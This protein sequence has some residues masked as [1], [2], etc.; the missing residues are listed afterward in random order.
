MLAFCI[1][2]QTNAQKAPQGQQLLDLLKK[3]YAISNQPA[4]KKKI[5]SLEGLLTPAIIRLEN[6]FENNS[7]EALENPYKIEERSNST[8][9]YS[10]LKKNIGFLNIGEFRINLSRFTNYKQESII[11]SLSFPDSLVYVAMVKN[12]GDD[13]FDT[14]IIRGK[15]PDPLLIKKLQQR[16]A[17][18]DPYAWQEIRRKEGFGNDCPPGNCTHYFIAIT[19]TKRLIKVS[20]PDDMFKILPSIKTGNDAFFQ[21]VQNDYRPKGKYIKTKDGFMVLL[22][23][24]ISNCPI[25]YADVL[26][27]VDNDGKLVM[28]GRVITKKTM[29]C[30]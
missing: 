9:D 4:I 27:Q 15:K 20:N 21:V 28:R 19:K 24:K 23:E 22:N 10:A 14:I 2:F 16:P 1:A 8:I 26:Y 18:I 25:D 29:L 6:V 3:S 30:N 5:D 12:H 13:K 17:A 7:I 11:K